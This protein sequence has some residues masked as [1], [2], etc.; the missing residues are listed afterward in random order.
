MSSHCTNE[1]FDPSGLHW[2]APGARPRMLASLKIDSIVSSF[3]LCDSCAG[4]AV[5][6]WANT[7][8]EANRQRTKAGRRDLTSTPGK[9]IRRRESLYQARTEPRKVVSY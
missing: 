5:P 2:I 8:T 3:V 1:T 6:A 7:N 4:A 9:E